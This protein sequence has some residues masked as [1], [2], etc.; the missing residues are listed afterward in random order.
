MTTI[1]DQFNALS[2]EA[3][4]LI[5]E[6]FMDQLRKYPQNPA[7]FVKAE[8]FKNR[9]FEFV[10]TAPTLITEPDGYLSVNAKGQLNHIVQSVGEGADYK[11]VNI[12]KKPGQNQGAH[13]KGHYG[14]VLSFNKAI[15]AGNLLNQS[16]ID[17]LVNYVNIWEA[18]G[19][20]NYKPGSKA[21]KQR[22]WLTARGVTG[23]M[24]FSLT[25][26]QDP[27]GGMVPALETIAWTPGDFQIIGS[28]I[29]E[30]AASVG[31]APALIMSQAGAA[32]T[33]NT[34]TT[35]RVIS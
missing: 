25:E 19:E 8:D 4:Y 28:G 6:Y 14:P 33:V 3:Q 31:S 11:L 15:V 20:D 35:G 9:T 13:N 1:L 26:R 29:E 21:A 32:P 27:K 30:R 10:L 16:D 5:S 34:A 7:F 24:T 23:Y 18:N 12:P 2:A 17:A 22:C